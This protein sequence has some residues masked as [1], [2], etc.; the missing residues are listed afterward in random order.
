MRPSAEFERPDDHAERPTRAHTRPQAPAASPN[1][2][3]ITARSDDCQARCHTLTKYGIAISASPT[4]TS[5]MVLETKYG[6]IIRA[7]P[8]ATGTALF[9]RLPYAKKPSPIEPN[10][11]PQRRDDVSK[12]RL[13]LK[14]RGRAQASPRRRER[15]LSSRAPGAK[16]LMH[17][18]RLQRFFGRNRVVIDHGISLDLNQPVPINKARDL[19]HSA[20]WPYVPKILP[21]NTG[22]QRPVLNAREQN[23]RSHHMAQRGACAFEGSRDNGEAATRLRSCVAPAD[24]A[25]IWSKR[26][27]TRDS[28]YRAGAHRPRKANSCLIRATT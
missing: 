25:A 13:T 23:P 11:N 1:C 18:G 28:D 15:T 12:K 27:G 14:L 6:K 2:S 7:T 19:Y 20:R 16:P 21:V 5:R 22:H 3:S 9:C 8:Q 24:S 10:S 26:C 17:L 4:M